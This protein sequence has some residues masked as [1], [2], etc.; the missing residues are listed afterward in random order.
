MLL[1]V[2]HS[3]NMIL[4]CWCLKHVNLPNV[5][6]CFQNVL[7]PFSLCLLLFVIFMKRWVWE[8]RWG[9]KKIPIRS[10]PCE[11]MSTQITEGPNTDVMVVSKEMALLSNILA[12]YTFITGTTHVVHNMRYSLNILCIF[13]VYI[14]HNLYSISLQYGLMS[15]Q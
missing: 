8:L 14:S 2:F 9:L 15:A 3:N 4:F 13:C 1:N 5:V 11:V 6:S 12:A 10:T 7:K